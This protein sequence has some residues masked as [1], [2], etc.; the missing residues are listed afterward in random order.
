MDTRKISLHRT[1]VQHRCNHWCYL[2]AYKT[3]QR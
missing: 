1:V 3:L 2:E